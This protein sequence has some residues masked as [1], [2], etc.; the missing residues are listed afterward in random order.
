MLRLARL[1]SRSTRNGLH[2]PGLPGDRSRSREAQRRNYRKLVAPNEETRTSPGYAEIRDRSLAE[3]LLEFR[4]NL[5]ERCGRL[6]GVQA[7]VD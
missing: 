5:P 7:H 3:V 2:T 1:P 4:S 6:S